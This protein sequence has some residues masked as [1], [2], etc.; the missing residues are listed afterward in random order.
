[1]AE[2][3]PIAPAPPILEFS[4]GDLALDFANTWGDRGRPET[5]RLQDFGD[6]LAFARQGGLVGPA[7]A[8][9][10]ARLA[11]RRTADAKAVLDG[12]IMLREALYRLLTG[13]SA[14]ATGEKRDRE[15]LNRAIR[16]AYPHLE[17]RALG[18]GLAWS[19]EAAERLDAVLWPV[20]KAA[21]ELLAS[22]D[23]ARVHE[24]EATDCTWL[25]LD[26]NRTGKR[27]WC[28]MASCGNREKARR[29]YRRRREDAQ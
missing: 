5:D 2:T 20:V 17:L 19:A 27:R 8:E 22:P 6:L 9:G 1:M 4:G 28:S 10:L 7:R 23:Q 13:R 14:G 29:H 3:L 15:V 26:R 24:C 16:E 18:E 25:F 12:A 11:V 21:A